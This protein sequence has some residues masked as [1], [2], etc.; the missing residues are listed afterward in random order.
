MGLTFIEVRKELVQNC[1]K[2]ST[3]YA[4][5]V[6]SKA[7]KS[8][9]ELINRELKPLEQLIIA[10]N[11][12]DYFEEKK[13]KG[14]S[15]PE[16]RTSAA[17]EL[18]VKSLDDVCQIL[19][20][21]G[22]IPQALD[23]AVTLARLDLPNWPA[24]RPFEYYLS[25]L[26]ERFT[27]LRE[28]LSM[29]FRI[30]KSKLNPSVDRWTYELAG[31]AEF[32]G[33]L[34]ELI[35]IDMLCETV[36]GSS[37]KR[38]QLKFV[39]ES[40]KLVYE[41]PVKPWLFPQEDLDPESV[42]AQEEQDN[43]QFILKS[44]VPKLTSFRTLVYMHAIDAT[45]KF[46]REQ[47]ELAKRQA[48][49]EAAEEKEEGEAEEKK[50][51]EELDPE[52]LAE[53]EREEKRLQR[54]AE[55]LKYGRYILWEEIIP[56]SKYDRWISGADKIDGVNIHV[57]ED[58]QDY[59]ITETYRTDTTKGLKAYEEEKARQEREKKEKIE[60]GNEEEKTTVKVEVRLNMYRPDKRIWN[61]FLEKES[62]YFHE[63]KYRIDANP[64]GIYEDG[65]VEAL[66]EDVKI[67]DEQLKTSNEPHWNALINYSYEIIQDD[68]K[69]EEQAALEGD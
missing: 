46:D 29:M 57:I 39:Y 64:F 45:K 42:E 16:F 58:M 54:E 22:K 52:A 2:L 37:L 4:K 68:F 41:S 21:C 63:H 65:R 49:K 1:T 47:E 50:A 31:N 55:D 61:F 15:I 24:V 5:Y 20:A 18:F 36:I 10:S 13:T 32:M 14:E 48:E 19:V 51:E 38:D 6:K 34:E 62:P 8:I 26:K 27:T 33:A 40:A 11:S 17:H 56:E 67:L 23:T 69:K 9:N 44:T 25:Q 59:I 53:K 43:L 35:K 12:L 30:G 7:F 3:E 66:W 60:A 28:T